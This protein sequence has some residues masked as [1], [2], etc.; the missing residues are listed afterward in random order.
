M[1]TFNESFDVVWMEAQMV[2]VLVVAVACCWVVEPKFADET[3]K[4]VHK[5]FNNCAFVRGPK[6]AKANTAMSAGIQY[7]PQMQQLPCCSC[8]QA[9]GPCS[10][11]ED[12]Q[13]AHDAC[14]RPPQVLQAP[15]IPPVGWSLGLFQEALSAM[16]KTAPSKEIHEANK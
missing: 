13:S 14:V 3:G 6:N 8:N 7:K 4:S 10:R 5:S 12:P 11:S 16:C 2:Y 1:P 15:M 9:N